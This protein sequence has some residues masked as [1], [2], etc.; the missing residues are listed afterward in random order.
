MVGLNCDRAVVV[1]AAGQGR[2]FGADGH[3]ALVPLLAGEGSLQRLL[4]QL[5]V[6]A[7]DWP[8][9]VVTGHRSTQVEAAVSRVCPQAH[10]L[11][12][13]NPA[14]GSPLTSLTA[15]LATLAKDPHLQGVL[16]LFADTIYHPQ[17]LLQLL[18]SPIDQP[19]VAS[20]PVDFGATDARIGLLLK[21]GTRQLMSLGPEVPVTH[22]V[23]APAVVWPRH[24]WTCLAEAVE[25]GLGLQ[26]QVLRQRLPGEPVRVLPLAAGQTRDID[27]PADA[28]DARLAM[29]R[30]WVVAG[31]RRT[32]SKE[33]RNLHEPDRLEVPGFLKIGESAKQAAIECS[34]LDWLRVGAGIRTIPKLL[35]SRG[36]SLLLEP[37]RGVRLYDLLR[38]LQVLEG[39]CPERAAQARAASLR[40]LHRSLEQLFE[41]Q[42]GLLTW[43]LAPCCPAYPLASHVA[44][45]LAMLVALLGLPPLHP[46]ECRELRDLRR[47]WEAED[48]LIPFRDATTKNIVVEIPQLGPDPGIDPDDRL[49]R[50][51]AW[52]D[53]G[54]CDHVRLVDVDWASVTHR[55]APEDDLFSLLAHAASL[56]ISERLLARLV[57]GVAAW[58]LAVAELVCGIH[59]GMRP[60]PPRAARALLVR[61]LRFGGR[62]LVYRL[63][64][65]A[66]FAVRFRYDDPSFYFER[67]PAA[68]QQLDPGF[69]LRFPCLMARLLQLRQA[70]ALLPPWSVGEAD[71]DFYRASLGLAVPYWQESPLERQPLAW[72]APSWRP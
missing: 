36:R 6:L 42:R 59:A 44:G 58:P 2:R 31:F 9:K 47:I 33:E 25:R 70:I 53:R 12:S 24:A 26:W 51:S 60:D 57:P 10:C 4:R 37:V 34:A 46:E 16:V 55:T 41:L 65:P 43:P 11:G 66:A 32:I 40:L 1:L 15:A 38:M 35:E 45:L 39:R 17:A 48:A 27:T 14:G 13:L 23:M 67:L 63:L 56:P 49:A 20:Q 28:R 62:K 54:D 8:I 19:L 68:L 61:Y 71:H 22:G 29:L 30:P 72:S 64:N 69:A 52:L 18:A 3:K 7:P 50:L 21:P 5:V